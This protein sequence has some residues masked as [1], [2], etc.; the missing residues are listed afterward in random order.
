[1]DDE[2][3]DSEIVIELPERS[4]STND[5]LDTVQLITQTSEQQLES[6]AEAKQDDESTD[7]IGSPSSFVAFVFIIIS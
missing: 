3:E 1:M 6:E 5:A 4:S 7:D 2:E